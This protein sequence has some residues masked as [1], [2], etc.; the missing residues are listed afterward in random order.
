MGCHR[1]GPRKTDDWLGGSQV[2][3]S[4]ILDE[5]RSY[6]EPH[7]GH[8]SFP[9]AVKRG[10]DPAPDGMP[11]I[12]HVGD[13]AVEQRQAEAEC[14]L[15]LDAEQERMRDHRTVSA[16]P[17]GQ[18]EIGQPAFQVGF[19]GCSVEHHPG[20]QDLR[21]LVDLSALWKGSEPR[22]GSPRTIG[23]GLCRV[24]DGLPCI[25][26]SLAWAYGADVFGSTNDAPAKVPDGVPANGRSGLRSRA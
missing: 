19:A 26:G 14:E 6:P 2:E 22:K 1:H 13:E 18:I 15:R 20:Q 4:G 25:Q 12:G 3:K 24:S 9:V 5:V 8:G 21:E 7:S 17:K 11:V 10:R 16:D 23:G